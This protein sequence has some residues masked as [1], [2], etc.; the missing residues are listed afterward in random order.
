MTPFE[1]FAIKRLVQQAGVGSTPEIEQALLM[2]LQS[3]RE[4]NLCCPYKG[5]LPEALCAEAMD[6]CS[7]PVV[8]HGNL[9]YFQ[10]NWAL[11]TKVLQKIAEIWKRPVPPFDS[12]RF[13]QALDAERPRLNAAQ[14]EAVS[15]GFGKSLTIFSGGPGT[16]KTYT[17]AAF[18]RL[19]AASQEN[20]KVL[21]TAPTGKAAAH[22]ESVFQAQ[23][24]EASL[25]LTWESMTLHRLLKLRPKTQKLTSEYLIDADLV[26]VDEASMMDGYLLL[27]LLNAVGPKTSAPSHKFLP[28][29]LCQS[30]GIEIVEEGGS[31]EA[32]H[33]PSSTT[34]S[35]G[36]L[37]QP[38]WQEFMGRS[39]RLL[40]L[41]D[42]NQLPPVDGVSFFPEIA[43]Q[44]GQKLTR[45]VRMGDSM[46]SRV[47]QAILEGKDIPRLPWQPD[48]L[49][50]WL[51]QRLPSP[52]HT[53][54]PDPLM[55]LQELSR[56]R[57]LCALRQGPFGVDSLN[58]QILARFQAQRSSDWFCIPILILQNSPG[59]ELYNGTP[60]V[61][62][63]KNGVGTAYFLDGAA[64]R[65]VAEMAL[66]RYETAFCLSIHKSQGSEFDE[67]LI[68]FGPGSERFG[69]EAL[70]T[71]VTRAKKIVEICAE[72]NAF[73]AAIH[74][75]G[76]LRSGFTDR[77]AGLHA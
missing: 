51:C 5:T 45:S 21:I 23:K 71:G 57:I 42:A 31:I 3:A 43:Q 47:S 8:K 59:Q 10:K 75:K 14:I 17:A 55:L 18:I 29:G 66:P 28:L 61:L 34:Q 73:Q 67:V 39:T 68:L 53:S 37:T 26:V 16:G 35:R 2:L 20:C 40:L 48:V 30:S 49:V 32:I 54:K 11:E 72:E 36:A 9:L 69:K 64:V 24:G 33:P 1:R 62:L 38:E 63:R 7:K 58:S 41:G 70:Y 50:D 46:V 65:A 6:D 44:L 77:L 60:G 27:H 15:Q 76:N 56:F 22:L 74:K 25:H 19:L 12:R 52:H 13:L 4:G